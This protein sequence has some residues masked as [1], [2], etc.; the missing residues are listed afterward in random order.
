MTQK[1]ITNPTGVTGTWTSAVINGQS[2]TGEVANYG[3]ISPGGI[4]VSG[5]TIH[6]TILDVGTVVGGITVDSASKI[7][8]GSA[9]GV[10]IAVENTSTFGGHISN[11]GTI[12]GTRVAIEVDDGVCFS[13]GITNSGTIAATSFCIFIARET[14]VAGG[15]VN[16]GTISAAAGPVSLLGKFRPSPAAFSTPAKLPAI[17][18]ALFISKVFRHSRA[19]SSTTVRLAA[20][21]LF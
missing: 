3:T 8:N 20:P 18:T 15:I 10:A 6:G 1:I 9:T 5:S 21:A 19:G 2:F 16:S 4:A 12:S 7:V 14:S 17:V 11:A 13:G